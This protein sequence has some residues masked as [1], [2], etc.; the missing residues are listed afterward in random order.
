MTPPTLNL[1]RNYRLLLFLVTAVVTGTVLWQARGALSPFVVGLSIAYLIAP[2]V[3][4]LHNA[5]PARVHARPFSRLI[6]IVVVYLVFLGVVAGAFVLIAPAV[7]DQAVQLAASAPAYYA[8]LQALASDLDHRY[9]QLPPDVARSIESMLSEENLQSLA[10]QVLGAAQTWALATFSAVTDTISWLLA[11]LIVPIWLVYILNDTGRVQ[12]GAMRLVPRD[13]RPDVEALRIVCDRVLGAYIRGQLFVAVILG[14]MFTL[15]LLASGVPYAMLLGLLA[16]ALAIIPFVGT[17]LGAAPAVVVAAFGGVDLLLRTL[18]VFVIVQQI[19]NWFISPRVQ[20]SSVALHPAMIMVVLVV[21]QQ[22][23]GPLGLLIS[24]P[25]AAIL[26]D[27]IHYLYL[28]VGEDG[29]D[30][31]GALTAVGYGDSVS[32]IMRAGGRLTA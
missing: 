3:N 8:R 15:G 32:A 14:V 13:I 23:M 17:F 12:S 5:M 26:R 21:G 29:P 4:R 27:V 6:A 7:A 22:I 30:P 11:F 19:D 18:A 28:R 2:L 16:G 24:V 25:L 31:I 20:S 10:T 9:R 1:F